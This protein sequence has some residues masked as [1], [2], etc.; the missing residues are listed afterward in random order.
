MEILLVLMGA[1]FVAVLIWIFILKMDIRRLGKRLKE[2]AELDTTE[3]VEK[4][5]INEA[6][7]TRDIVDSF[8]AL[9]EKKKDGLKENK[10]AKST[11]RD[12]INKIASNNKQQFT[13]I[14]NKL[15]TVYA[16]GV[17]LDTQEQNLES[18]K[19]QLNELLSYSD[20]LIEYA[21]IIEG[22]VSISTRQNNICNVVKDTLGERRL[23]FTKK[24]IEVYSEIP[25]E[26]IIC[27]CDDEIL[28]RV[29]RYLLNNVLIHGK[30]MVKV[31]IIN[32]V[33]E[34]SN[35]A[36]DLE[37]INVE[38][39]FD[40]FSDTKSAGATKT[41]GIG[42]AISKGLIEVMKGRITA[43]AVGDTM[44]MQIR[45][46]LLASSNVNQG[47]PEDYRVKPQ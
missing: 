23:D 13:E 6:L 1:A 33:I 5:V 35:R 46:P 38:N 4:E 44:V 18:I 7:G 22:N 14:L 26:P 37:S 41:M 10:R 29:L 12:A 32:G 15:Q 27:I 20:K 2:L 31:A 43:E 45:L 40:F 36:D 30:E 19:E 3:L 17:D 25:E 8:N 24:G 39:I 11:L 42:L 47:D 21:D 9:I 28:K 16:P 34:I